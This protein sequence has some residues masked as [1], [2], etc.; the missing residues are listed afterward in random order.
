[1]IRFT[2]W[3]FWTVAYAF[4][5]KPAT[6]DEALLRGRRTWWP[7]KQFKPCCYHNDDG[8]FWQVWFA[9]D[10]AHT[11]SSQR[12]RADVDVSM[13]TGEIVGLTI[14]DYDLNSLRS[15]ADILRAS[16]KDGPTDGH[17]GGCKWFHVTAGLV[18]VLG[19]CTHNGNSHHVFR[20]PHGASAPQTPVWCPV[21]KCEP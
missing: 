13:E 15:T 16:R 2:R 1:M 14:Y 21:K 20:A 6:L 4:L 17:C 8:G 3:L 5:P 9:D 10:E 18:E 12:L 7:W 19:S 11:V